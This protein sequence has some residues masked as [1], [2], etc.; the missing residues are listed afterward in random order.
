MRIAVLSD[1]HANLVALD[2]VLAEVD[3]VDAVWHLGDVVGYGPD[4]NGVVDRLA[5][6]GAIGVRGNH[7]AAAIG[8]IGVDWFNPE[9][10]EAV[11]WTRDR[12][13][14]PA[15]DW[16][17]AQPLERSEEQVALVHG[18]FRDPTWEY[19]TQGP[20]ARANLAVLAERGIRHGLFGHTH[21][22]SAFRD[23]DGR[24][25]V[26]RPGPGSSLPLDERPM[27]LNPGS[28]GQPRDGDPRAS[29]LILDTVARTAT[30]QRVAYDIAAVQRAMSAERLPER[31]ALRLAFGQ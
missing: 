27:L 8:A 3:P 19:V 7:D 10:R 31:L 5:R 4:P 6:R 9:A 12:I 26:I 30:W 16:L 29:C 1:V 21:L 17:A 14:R 23:D 28:V 2:A 24:L 22:P 20:V 13:D 25:E 11:L 15:H 18:S